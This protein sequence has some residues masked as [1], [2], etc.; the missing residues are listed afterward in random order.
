MHPSRGVHPIAVVAFSLNPI[1]RDI[2]FL[3]SQLVP[4][5]QLHFHNPFR[6]SY[7]PIGLFELREEILDLHPPIEV[8]YF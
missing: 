6:P 5:Q 4:G 3:A 2:I 8:K 7:S 1:F